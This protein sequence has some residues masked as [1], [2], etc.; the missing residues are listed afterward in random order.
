MKAALEETDQKD[1]KAMVEEGREI[2]TLE[3]RDQNEY[4]NKGEM[5]RREKS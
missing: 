3:G 5:E 2:I 4:E 1:M